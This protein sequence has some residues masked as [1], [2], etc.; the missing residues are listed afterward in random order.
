MR[1]NVAIVLYVSLL[2]VSCKTYKGDYLNAEEFTFK[3]F[4]TIDKIEGRILELSNLVMRP[5]DILVKDSVL[6]LIE[7]GGGNLFH[8]YNLNSQSLINDCIGMG[9][10]PDEMI[11][12]EFMSCDGEIIDIV[13]LAT[14]TVYRYSLQDFI[15]SK[16]PTPINRVKLEK[17]VFICAQQVN[18]DIYGY[19]YGTDKRLNKFDDAGKKVGE[20][21]DYPDSKK[22][23]TDNEKM[24]AFYMKFI[25]NG[26]D[27]IALCHY[28][29]DLIEI[30][31][32]NGVLQK[33]IHGPDHFLAHFKQRQDGLLGSLPIK[34]MNRDAYM[35]PRNASNGFFVLYNGGYIDDHDHTSSCNNLFLFSWDG[36]P[37]NAYLFDDPIFSFSVDEGNR[38]IYGISNTPEYHIVEYS[39]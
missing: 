2:I 29:T 9:Q 39:F 4:H 27:K 35:S 24:D 7:T 31:D 25:N 30:Y 5:T 18:N 28:M 32:K 16:T 37:Q 13:D 34:G 21:I 17:Q 14:S 22:E 23:Y 36:I 10:G 19:S 12:P 20:L 38:K 3:D 6:I 11:D 1:F 26:A 15:D 8:V 33:S